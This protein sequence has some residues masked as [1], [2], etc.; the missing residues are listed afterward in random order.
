MLSMAYRSFGANL[1]GFLSEHEQEKTFQ[2]NSLG[3]LDAAPTN[4][5][6]ESRK[7]A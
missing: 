1:S 2:N 7:G 5:I 4:G 3:R 6:V